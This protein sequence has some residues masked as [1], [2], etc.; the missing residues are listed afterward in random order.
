MPTPLQPST[1]TSNSRGMAN[2]ARRRLKPLTSCCKKYRGDSKFRE[3]TSREG[4]N[5]LTKSLLCA[6][7]SFILGRGCVHVWEYSVQSGTHKRQ[8]IL[9][10]QRSS[11]AYYNVAT[12]FF[13]P[14]A[15][16]IVM[17]WLLNMQMDNS[18]VYRSRPGG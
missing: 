6:I 8:G 2:Q 17:I 14:T 11:R 4:T 5:T 9:A 1:C 13:Y 7:L 10:N 3:D 12:M 18:G 16:C 15:R